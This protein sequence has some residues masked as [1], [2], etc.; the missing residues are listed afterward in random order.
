MKEI[1]EDK[2]LK[3]KALKYSVITVIVIILIALIVAISCFGKIFNFSLIY[4]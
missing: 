3:E 4:F 1:P 2:A